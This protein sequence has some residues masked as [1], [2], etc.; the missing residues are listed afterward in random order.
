MPMKTPSANISEKEKRQ[1]KKYEKLSKSLQEGMKPYSAKKKSGE[2]LSVLEEIQ[3]KNPI[4]TTNATEAK[5]I[6]D[7]RDR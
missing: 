5:Y 1:L 4:N 2:L 6:R 7:D 3:T